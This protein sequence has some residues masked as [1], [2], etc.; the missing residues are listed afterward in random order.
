VS[1]WFKR[2]RL[3]W[4]RES[5]SIFGF[6]HREHIEKKFRV[7]TPQASQDIRDAMAEWPLLMHYNVSAKRYELT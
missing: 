7:S 5:V 4:I 1:T 6:I 2:H 3:E